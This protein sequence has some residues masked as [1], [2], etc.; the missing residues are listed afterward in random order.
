M[1]AVLAGQ[2]GAAPALTLLATALTLGLA[3]KMKI[4]CACALESMMACR[5]FSSSLLRLPLTPTSGWLQRV[6]VAWLSGWIQDRTFRKRLPC[7]TSQT[8]A[9]CPT[10]NSS[11]GQDGSSRLS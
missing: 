8:A 3:S 10:L 7:A 6:M 2:G 9:L 1:G 4:L 5:Y 11:A